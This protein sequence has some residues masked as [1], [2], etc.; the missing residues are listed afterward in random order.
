MNSIELVKEIVEKLFPDEN[1][2]AFKIFSNKSDDKK[3]EKEM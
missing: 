3:M 2:F 1:F